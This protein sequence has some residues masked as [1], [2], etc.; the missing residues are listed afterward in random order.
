MTTFSQALAGMMR[1][2]AP[3]DPWAGL[4]QVTPAASPASGNALSGLPAV[5]AGV[6][7]IFAEALAGRMSEFAVM[8]QMQASRAQAQA[9]RFSAGEA[10]VEINMERLQGLARR[11]SL[12]E[13]ATRFVAEA[14]VAFAASGQDVTTGQARTITDRAQD[15]LENALT[16]DQGTQEIRVSQMRLRREMALSQA[17]MVEDAG[18]LQ[19][20]TTRLEF[21]LGRAQRG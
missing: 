6:E 8:T 19:A 13:E 20:S 3:T 17:R 7:S 12:K 10:D 15:R 18:E 21:L 4:R 1:P 5:V 16:I 11:N 2:P 14:N 9:L